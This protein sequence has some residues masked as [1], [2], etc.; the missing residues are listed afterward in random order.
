M[1][2]RLQSNGKAVS[3]WS[4]CG[5]YYEC[6]AT[7]KRRQS[8]QQPTATAKLSAHGP[9]A[10]PNYECTATAKRRQS[11]GKATAKQWQSCQPMV[12]LRRLTTSVL[13]A[14]H[15]QRDF[16]RDVTHTHTHTHTGGGLFADARR[17]MTP[18]THIQL[19]STTYHLSLRSCIAS[20]YWRVLGCA[21]HEAFHRVSS[22]S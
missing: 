15:C 6:I 19:C 9:I 13:P 4:H 2:K 8:C 11:D 5:A 18:V 1:A 3:P 16:G 12:P 7:A 22:P 17:H 14:M 20:Q 10:A 21:A